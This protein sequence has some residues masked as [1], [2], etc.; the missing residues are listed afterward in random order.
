[1]EYSVRNYT[2]FLPDHIM[3]PGHIL[4]ISLKYHEYNSSPLVLLSYPSLILREQSSH[5][6]PTKNK[7]SNESARGNAGKETSISIHVASQVRRHIKRCGTR[8]SDQYLATSPSSQ[9][10][11]KR[12]P[13]MSV[14][15][16]KG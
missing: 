10:S 2:L 5:P 11:V 3:I 6:E 8:S 16:V 14:H 15:R 1:M 9:D 13:I 4:I 12:K 7:V